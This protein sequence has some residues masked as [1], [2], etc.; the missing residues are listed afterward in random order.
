[1]SADGNL[2]A[3][4][5]RDRTVRLWDAATGKELAVLGGH[6]DQVRAVALSRDGKTLAS[7]GDDRTIRIWNVDAALK[8]GK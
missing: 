2:V 5:S 3:T 1:V 8:K 4:G 7:A 6:T